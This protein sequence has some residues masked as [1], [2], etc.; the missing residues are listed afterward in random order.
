M[1]HIENLDN[2]AITAAVHLAATAADVFS[3][4]TVE[5]GVNQGCMFFNISS[6]NLVFIFRIISHNGLHFRI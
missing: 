1:L 2:P 4:E 5:Q 3:M 6:K